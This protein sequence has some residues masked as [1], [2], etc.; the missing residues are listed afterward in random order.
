MQNSFWLFVS[1]LLAQVS[2]NTINWFSIVKLKITEILVK[3]ILLEALLF[4]CSFIIHIARPSSKNIVL[5]MI[6]YFTTLSN[7]LAIW[8]KMARSSKRTSKLRALTGR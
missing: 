1:K 8:N 2:V 4:T 3:V 5:S 6:L 7:S